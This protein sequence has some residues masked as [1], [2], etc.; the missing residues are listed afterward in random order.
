MNKLSNKNTKYAQNKEG[1]NME[2]YDNCIKIL[3]AN[4]YCFGAQKRTY[5]YKLDKKNADNLG[6]IVE[7]SFG[8]KTLRG[9]VLSIEKVDV[10]NNRI[11]INNDEFLAEKLKDINKV[12][13][14]NLVSD[15]FL[16]FLKK[17]AFYNIVHVERIIDNVVLSAWMNKKRD[18]KSLKEIK[19]NK[20]LDVKKNQLKKIQLSEEQ[21]SISDKICLDVFNVYVLYGAMGSGKTYIFLESVRKVLLKDNTSQVLIMVPEI[22]LTSNLINIVY[23]FC[24]IEPVIWHSSVSTAKKKV[25]YENII[26]GSIRIVIS[27]RSGLLLPY[28]NLS[29]IVIDE[30]HDAS[31][32]Q[33][34]VPVYNARDMAVLR[35]KYENIPI[36]LSS[37][38]PSIETIN[39]VMR[40]KYNLLRIN[41]QFFHIKPPKIEIIDMFK[42]KNISKKKDVEE[43]KEANNK[44]NKDNKDNKKTNDNNRNIVFNDKR[45]TNFISEQARYA[46]INTLKKGEQSMIFINRR[47]YSRTLKCEDCGGEMMCKNC[48]NLLSFHK[49]E[50]VLKCHYCEYSVKN[51][52]KCL[53]CN[54]ENLVS[55]NG[56][57]VEQIEEEI[58]SFCD[59]KTLIFSS[60]EV[61]KEFDLELI[62]NKIKNGNVDIIIG[63]QIITKGHH[64]PRLTNIIVLDIDRMALDCDDF[65][66]FEHMFQLLYQLSG[67]AGREKENAKIF[68]QTVNPGNLIL[69]FLKNHGI[70]QFYEYEIERRKQFNLPPYYR[71]IAIIISSRKQ[72]LAYNTSVSVVKEL[73]KVFSQNNTIKMLGPTDCKIHFLKKNYRY[74]ILVEA[75]KNNNDIFVYLN[76]FYN[77]FDCPRNV[78]L[79]IDVN[80]YVFL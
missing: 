12:L 75:D 43:I 79:K 60:D 63:T 23:N 48:D 55:S 67:R 18:F 42:G 4:I 19:K 20:C 73:R 50:N 34:E 38:T 54:G 44:D 13:Y 25:Y 57:G 78:L 69:K 30:E 46:I 74:R 49:Q 40:K 22:A 1:E 68:I 56:A 28:K 77:S 3:V 29:L 10:I 24:G 39:N 14:K 62:S 70:K 5:C 52:K 27:T 36:I 11:T 65:R 71:F 9:I 80:P 61:N 35:A 64:F 7:V 58:H 33:N 16:D 17:M 72:E 6:S 51:I 32:K 21:S 37:A 8:K 59:A 26:N 41:T 2:I 76:N 47:G 31:Y 53:N 45:K 15:V 66:V